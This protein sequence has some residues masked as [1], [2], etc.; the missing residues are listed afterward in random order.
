MSTNFNTPYDFV[1]LKMILYYEQN[2]TTNN[3]SHRS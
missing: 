3:I 1:E 2:H